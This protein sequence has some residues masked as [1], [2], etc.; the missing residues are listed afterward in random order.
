MHQPLHPAGLTP[1]AASR[2]ARGLIAALLVCLAVAASV[3]F[4]L[5]RRGVTRHTLTGGQGVTAPAPEPAVPTVIESGP[6]LFKPG[7]PAPPFTLAD[8][9]TGEKVSLG[10]YR[11]KQPVV[12][13]LSSFG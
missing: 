13:L 5:D 3:V 11:G 10:D 6:V 1:R 8:P 7:T 9:R 4:A 12:L 2:P